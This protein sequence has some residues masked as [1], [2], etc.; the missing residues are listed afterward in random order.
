MLSLSNKLGLNNSKNPQSG[1]VFTNEYSLNFDGIDDYVTFGDKNDFSFGNGTSDTPFSVSA[2]IKMVD[3]TKF[4]ILSKSA[5]GAGNI[6]WLFGVGGT[7]KLTLTLFDNAGSNQIKRESAAITSDEG[8]WI[9]VVGTYNGSGSNT[10]INI[11]INGV[12]ANDSAGGAGTYVAMHNGTA[13]LE[14]GRFVSDSGNA[15][16]SDGNIDEV[17][18]WN[19]ELSA[20]EVTA[21]YN[22]G[23]PTDLSAA[24]NLVGYWRNGDTAG[25]SVYP[26]IE[27]NSTSG[28]GGIMTNMDSGNIVTD[29]P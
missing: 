18:L 24:S 5:S 25:T 13:A 14:M 3:A 6:E 19:K 8:S 28:N 9:N 4:R 15:T 29:V 27:D 20:G 16:Y 10:D 1:A 21:I 17:S 11:Y 26:V 2:W 7:D 12:D 23:T 22:S